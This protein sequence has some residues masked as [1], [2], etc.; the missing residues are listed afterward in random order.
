MTEEKRNKAIRF[1]VEEIWSDAANKQ[2][3][4]LTDEDLRYITG[5]MVFQKWAARIE[6]IALYKEYQ[7]LIQRFYQ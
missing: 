1:Y 7:A 3:H 5:T 2:P 4:E 6:I